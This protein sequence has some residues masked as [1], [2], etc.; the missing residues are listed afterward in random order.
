MHDPSD[1]LEEDDHLTGPSLLPELIDRADA[2]LGVRLPGTY[3][4]LLQARN[5]GRLTRR[6]VATDFPTSRAADQV[7]VTAPYASVTWWRSGRAGGTV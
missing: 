7:Q 4:R 6:C 5:E 1:L 3:V 2:I